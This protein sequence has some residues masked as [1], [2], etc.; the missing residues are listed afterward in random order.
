MSV[1]L[2]QGVPE[3]IE[4]FADLIASEMGLEPGRSQ[5]YN[6]RRKIKAGDDG[7]FVDVALLGSRPF[8]VKRGYSV[9][10]AQTDLV[11]G[12]TVNV[13]EVVQIDV[14]SF[15]ESARLR[16]FDVLFALTS[17]AAQRMCEANAMKIGR[18]PPSFV[19]ASSQEG[20]AI[21]NRFVLT[22]NLLRSYGRTKAAPTYDQFSIPPQIHVNK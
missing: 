21:L 5:I 16:K 4:L 13:Q 1:L 3:T 8:A 7:I 14:F 9:D 17:T 18:V 11:E 19:D 20:G 10:P 15:D 2:E 12:Q 6:Q 22:L